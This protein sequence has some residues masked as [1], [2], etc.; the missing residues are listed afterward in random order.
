MQK[1]LISKIKNQ[2]TAATEQIVAKMLDLPIEK[3]PSMKRQKDG[4]VR[5]TIT[6]SQEDMEDLL[7][8]KEI[9]S[10]V[11]PSLQLP[12]LIKLILKRLLKQNDPLAKPTSP[13]EVKTRPSSNPRYVSASAQRAVQQR[14]RCCQ[15]KDPQT[16][17]MCG[18]KFQL[19]IDHIIPIWAGGTNE[20]EKSSNSLQLSQ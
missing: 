3:K 5:M 11:E 18:S 10:H 17:Q 7:R 1:E 4:S 13:S 6:F 19:E 9:L 16:G 14:D 20:L 2:T 8:A 15:W 12:D